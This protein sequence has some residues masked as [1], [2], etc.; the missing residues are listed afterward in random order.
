MS[1]GKKADHAVVTGLAHSFHFIPSVQLG[2]RKPPGT[3]TGRAVSHTVR[4][5]K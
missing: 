4:H 1:S 2:E 5:W 3:L